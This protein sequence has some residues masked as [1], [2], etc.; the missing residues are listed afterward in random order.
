MEVKSLATLDTTM[1]ARKKRVQAV[2]TSRRPKMSEKAPMG[3]WKIVAPSK[4]LV[5]VQK[6]SMAVPWRLSAI[7]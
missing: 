2:R 5:P 4:K 6:A 3:S 7:T 1:P